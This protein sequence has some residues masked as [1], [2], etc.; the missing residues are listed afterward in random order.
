MNS[1]NMQANK[2]QTIQIKE[3]DRD[4]YHIEFKRI[5]TDTT[6][7]YP[8]T[9]KRIQTYSKKEYAGLTLWVKKNG[10]KAMA[11]DEMRVV[12]DPTIEAEEK[13]EVKKPVRRKTAQKV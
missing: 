3:C 13:A 6:G 2:D 7:K 10:L 5:I 9:D 4:Q 11:D 1:K 12:H 8:K